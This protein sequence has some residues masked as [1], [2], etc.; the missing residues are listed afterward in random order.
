MLGRVGARL[1]LIILL[2]IYY[3]VYVVGD[4]STTY[5]L[6]LNDPHGIFHEANPIGRVMYLGY[7]LLGLM[8]GKMMTFIP[9]AVMVVVFEARFRGVHWFRELVETVVLGLITY[10]LMVL[11]NNLAAMMIL[12]VF[13][14]ERY[15]LQMY[16]IIRGLILTLSICLV[17]VLTRVH[18]RGD[19]SRVTEVVVGTVVVVGP[20][21]LFDPLFDYLGRN[22]WSLL[23]YVVALLTILGSFIYI[24]GEIKRERTMRKVK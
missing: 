2:L 4:L 16:P 6:I 1:D 17:I 9:L 13:K 20:F 8:L 18:G 15:L 12:Q 3:A 10:S 14:G 23:V 24:G 21:L 11:L 5:W 19:L 7:G 22:V